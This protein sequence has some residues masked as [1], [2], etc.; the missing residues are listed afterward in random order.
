KAPIHI[1]PGLING[2]SN[3]DFRVDQKL[4]RVFGRIV[5]Q[6]DD[7][8][9]NST[10]SLMNVRIMQGGRLVSSVGE[11][12]SDGQF[13]VEISHPLFAQS[14]DQPINLIAEPSNI[15]IAL[16]KVTKKLSSD[17]L[18]SDLDVGDI[19][20]GK[21][22]KPISLSIEVHGSDDSNIGN[23]FLYLR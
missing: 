19:N 4:T 11:V 5:V 22:K 16:P 9:K 21:L 8:L 18:L 2:D 6:D 3:F 10:T 17:Q 23:A 7:V 14:Q 20:L 13:S 1:H 12:K 15:E